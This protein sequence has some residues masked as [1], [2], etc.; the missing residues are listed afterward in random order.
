MNIEL[1]TISAASATFIKTKKDHNFFY[2][3]LIKAALSKL[4]RIQ[5]SSK[6]KKKDAYT[7]TIFKSKSHMS[8]TGGQNSGKIE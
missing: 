6:H 8:T 4:P 5:F 3:L 7:E 1:A 2:I